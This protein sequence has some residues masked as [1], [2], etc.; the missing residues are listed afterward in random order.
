[1]IAG[2]NVKHATRS[3]N[4]RR[5]FHA[6]GPKSTQTYLQVQLGIAHIRTANALWNLAMAFGGRII[7]LGT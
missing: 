3:L 6:T 2:S 1:M 5:T 7:L 4:T